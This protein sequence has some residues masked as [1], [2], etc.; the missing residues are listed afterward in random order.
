MSRGLLR[1]KRRRRARGTG[2]K[3]KR[4]LQIQLEPFKRAKREEPTPDAVP[5][6]TNSEPSADPDDDWGNWR[7]GG[8]G[9]EPTAPT[10]APGAAPGT[11]VVILG[12]AVPTTPP[13]YPLVDA[14]GH[15][16][17]RPP[18]SKNPPRTP[19]TACST[20]TDAGPS[21]SRSSMNLPVHLVSYS[22]RSFGRTTVEWGYYT[23][24]GVPMVIV[25]S[26]PDQSE[27]LEE[28][29]GDPAASTEEPEE[30][31][32]PEDPSKKTTRR[33]IR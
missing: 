13:L 32:P 8:K 11:P 22:V 25:P 6:E 1:R 4:K 3:M 2:T 12:E 14:A 19:S 5:A 30:E 21:S 24:E 15:G 28:L 26:S 20:A 18:E 10:E 23:P 17:F 7:G 16:S 33:P 29:T 31:V 27:E 9:K